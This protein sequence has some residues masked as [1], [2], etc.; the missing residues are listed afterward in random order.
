MPEWPDRMRGPAPT[1]TPSHGLIRLPDPDV[2]VYRIFPLWFFE[3]MLRTRQLV[4]VAPHRWEDPFEVLSR[5]VILVDPRFEPPETRPLDDFL[6]PAYAQC[7]SRNEESDT[8]WRAYSRVFKDAHF[9]RNLFPRDEGVQVRSSPRKLLAAMRGWARE[10]P[11]YACFV[12]A[13]RYLPRTG[14]YHHLEA[15]LNRHGPEALGHG[16]LRAELLLLKRDAFAHE[17]EVRIIAVSEERKEEDERLAVAV[18][19]SEVFDEVTFE[20]RL[21]PAE[22]EGRENMARSLGYRGRFRVSEL[23]RQAKLEIVMPGGWGEE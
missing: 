2:P 7:W 12:G 15:L 11:G 18:D 8:L 9:N 13:V 23:Y 20:P 16:E 3:E 22:R 21:A 6:P 5:S 14:I 10:N 4:L 17:A 19:P 1:T